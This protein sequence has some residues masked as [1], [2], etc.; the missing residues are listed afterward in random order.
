MDGTRT[1]HLAESTF[2]KTFLMPL[3][4]VPVSFPPTS[5]LT[6]GDYKLAKTPHSSA[7]VDSLLSF[8]SPSPLFK[9][10]SKV[11]TEIRSNID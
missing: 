3:P 2:S 5:A 6:D 4:I 11:K 8:L 10:L 7:E 1:R 9:R